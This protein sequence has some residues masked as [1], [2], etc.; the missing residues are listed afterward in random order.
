MSET[1]P[2]AP[3][4]KSLPEELATVFAEDPFNLIDTKPILSQGTRDTRVLCYE[5]PEPLPLPPDAML[6]VEYTGGPNGGAMGFFYV[7][8]TASQEERAYASMLLEVSN[9]DTAELYDRWVRPDMRT[10]AGVGTRLRE[11]AEDWIAQVAKAYGHPITM[12]AHVSQI[13][14]IDW[15]TKGGYTP[16]EESAPI[17]EDLRAHPERYY[18]E[19]QNEHHDRWFLV[20]RLLPD[21]TPESEPIRLTLEKVIQPAS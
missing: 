13:D 8:P 11:Q 6:R 2:D 7:S 9:P 17:L 18:V 4:L 14:V 12:V 10:H 5:R 3:K 1:P 20:Y 16:D 15:L 19:D 21:G